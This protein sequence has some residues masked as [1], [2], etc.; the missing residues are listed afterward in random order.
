M[1]SATLN[2]RVSPRRMLSAREAA[3]YCCL[4]PKRFGQVCPVRPVELAGGLTA[5]DMRDLDAWI[6]G[7]KAGGA[8]DDDAI[9]ERLR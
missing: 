2:L 8:D 3:E 5:F 4:A 1:S 6:D 9:V 7:L